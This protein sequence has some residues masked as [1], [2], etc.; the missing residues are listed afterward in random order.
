[1]QCDWWE[2]L[3]LLFLFAFVRNLLVV[4]SGFHLSNNC[5]QKMPDSEGKCN[6]LNIYQLK[7]R[8]EEAVDK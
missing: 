2:E 3:S 1:M 4:V 5:G 7:M 8:Q 6:N